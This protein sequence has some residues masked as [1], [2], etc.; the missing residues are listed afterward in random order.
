MTQRYSQSYSRFY[1]FIFITFSTPLV[2]AAIF[3]IIDRFLFMDISDNYYSNF[4]SD[5]KIV[6]FG[7]EA[8]IILYVIILYFLYFIIPSLRLSSELLLIL[9]VSTIMLLLFM[10][11]GD[12]TKNENYFILKINSIRSFLSSKF[13]KLYSNQLIEHFC[14]S[15]PLILPFPLFLLYLISNDEKYYFLYSYG[16]F[17]PHIF[18]IIFN[19]RFLPALLVFFVLIAG[20]YLTILGSK[21]TIEYGNKIFNQKRLIRLLSRITVGFGIISGYGLL[22]SFNNWIIITLVITGLLILLIVKYLYSFLII[23]NN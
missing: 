22:A 5:F 20:I 14:W 12:L 15:S 4:L 6:F 8:I 7:Y 18:L 16:I 10:T 11:G 3:K 13:N 21:K 23:K 17:D 9:I 1:L 2:T 19:P